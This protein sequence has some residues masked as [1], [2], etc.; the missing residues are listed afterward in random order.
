MLT[1]T[2]LGRRLHDCIG[3]RRVGLAH[4]RMPATSGLDIIDLLMEGHGDHFSCFLRVLRALRG[5][6]IFG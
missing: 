4:C 1:Q 3:D 6:S 5:E 2:R